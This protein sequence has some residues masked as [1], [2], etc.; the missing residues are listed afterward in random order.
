MDR[1]YV[2]I[3]GLTRE[4]DIDAVNRAMP[5]Y[6]GFV[7]APSRRRITAGTA[8][9][10]RARL[11]PAIRSVGVFVDASPEDILLPLRE[12]IIDM[13]QLH[14]HEDEAFV[15]RIQ[16]Q[17]GKPVIKAIRAASGADIDAWQASAVDHLLLD[18]GAGSGQPFDWEL[19]A[20]CTR[21]YFLA[22]GLHEGN[23]AQAIAR[24]HPYGVDISSGV[25]TDGQKDAEKIYRAV[26]LVRNIPVGKDR[27][28]P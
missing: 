11:H 18:S 21:P 6:A 22:G 13:A 4:E 8:S 14:G 2:K 15:R 3:C 17:S 19:A 1:V 7:F 24:L 5:D 16:E 25:E 9:R 10:L 23:L 20:H 12:G 26:A 27:E 28:R